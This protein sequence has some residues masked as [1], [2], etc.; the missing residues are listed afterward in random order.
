MSFREYYITSN[1]FCNIVYG[2]FWIIFAIASKTD[3]LHKKAFFLSADEIAGYKA[4]YGVCV[5][6]MAAECPFAQGH[7]RPDRKRRQSGGVKLSC[8]FCTYNGR[9]AGRKTQL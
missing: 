8:N 2:F 3:S 6:D 7:R 9:L 1:S 5:T 4:V